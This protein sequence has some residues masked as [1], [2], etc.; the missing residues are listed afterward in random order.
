MKQTSDD[1]FSSMKP[2][3]LPALFALLSLC[4]AYAQEPLEP[5]AEEPAAATAEE[6][7]AALPDEVP[8]T[9]PVPDETVKAPPVPEICLYKAIT[10]IQEGRAEE[11]YAELKRAAKAEH[12]EAVYNLALCCLQGIGCEKDELLAVKLFNWAAER[13]C[14]EAMYNLGL[15]FARG[16]GVK[17]NMERAVSC[18]QKAADAGI[19]DAML[20][21]AICYRHGLGVEADE[22]RADA[23]QEA[24]K[25]EK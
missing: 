17:Q 4:C 10:L 8:P 23:L 19:K 12:T 16:V 5:V 15:C 14:A 6:A 20:N 7:A 11:G 25:A 13:G 21:L 24:A 1:F 9:I 18:W 3:F 2:P 22:A